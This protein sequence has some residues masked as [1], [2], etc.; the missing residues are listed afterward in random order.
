MAKSKFNL[1]N[2][3]LSA[4]TRDAA[5]FGVDRF[6]IDAHAGGWACCGEVVDADPC[7]VHNAI[8]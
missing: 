4:I 5:G 2:P 3:F 7:L 8:Q 6:V 1:G